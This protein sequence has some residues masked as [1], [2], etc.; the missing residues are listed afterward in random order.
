MRSGTDRAALI[1]LRAAQGVGAAL[2]VPG[3]LAL[4]DA[5]VDP[6]ERGRVIRLW[7]GLSGVA[8]AAGPL[9][10]GWLTERCRGGGS[11]SST[12]RSRPHH[13]DRP[14]VRSRLRA[15]HAGEAAASFAAMVLGGA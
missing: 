9:L 6:D 7:S 2:L 15:R 12:C 14:G 3:S 10:G 13:H 8:T 4:I 1:G 5:L 11:S